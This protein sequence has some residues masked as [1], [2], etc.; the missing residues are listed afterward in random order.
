[1]GSSDLLVSSASPFI[2]L[3]YFSFL[4]KKKSKL[5][6]SSHVREHEDN[7]VEH[8]SIVPLHQQ[9][10]YKRASSLVFLICLM[11]AMDI[12]KNNRNTRERQIA[13]CN[14]A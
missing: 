2:D 12:K 3:V 1:M 11:K 7:S 8:V 5:Y 9:A 4:K 10:L 14:E 13:F 6:F